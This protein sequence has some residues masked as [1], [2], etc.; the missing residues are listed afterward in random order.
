[1]IK[2]SFQPYS[3]KLIE[4]AR[5]LRKNSTLSEVLLWE[6][7]KGRQLSGYKFR[8]QTAIL[9]YIVDFYCKELNLI[10]EVDGLS[11]DYKMD[12]DATR[13]KNLESVGI[14]LLR[15]NDLEIK[16]DIQ[17]VLQRIGEW[18]DA[19]PPLPRPSGE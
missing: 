11:H 6:K 19:N 12:Y 17:N 2:I 16:K 14:M 13:Q 8:R 4:R 9:K 10:I 3:H 7:L 5:G 1:M 18:I 15:F